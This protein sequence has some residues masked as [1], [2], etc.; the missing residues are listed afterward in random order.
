MRLFLT[1]LFCL[2]AL[3]TIGFFAI[4]SPENLNPDFVYGGF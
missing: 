2:L 1:G 3:I 4:I